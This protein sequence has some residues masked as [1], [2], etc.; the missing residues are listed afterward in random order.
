MRNRVNKRVRIKMI[1]NVIN[2]RKY[3]PGISTCTKE[4]RFGR[5]GWYAVNRADNLCGKPQELK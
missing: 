5:S 3:A 2:P 1:E 4:Q